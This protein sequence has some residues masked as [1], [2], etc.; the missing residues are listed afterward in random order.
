MDETELKRRA[1]RSLR[2]WLKRLVLQLASEHERAAAEL[3]KAIK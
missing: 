3:R 1:L 2:W